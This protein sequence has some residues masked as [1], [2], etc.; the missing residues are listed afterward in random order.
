[1]S[2]MK[3][4]EDIEQRNIID[5]LAN[6]VARNGPKFEELTKSKQKD[7]P[8]FAFLFGGEHHEYYKW[9]VALE[10]TQVEA[11]KQLEAQ[12][13]QQDAT[14]AA[15]Q[16]PHAV[17]SEH[18]KRDNGGEKVA[19]TL[20]L[21]TFRELVQKLI[22]ACTKDNIQNGKNWI[23]NNAKS[24][25]QKEIVAK[26]LFRRLLE[27]VL[28]FQQKLHIVYLA[29]DVLHHSRKK[30]LPQLQD[31]L[32]KYILPIIGVVIN[33]ESIAN[34]QKIAKVLKIWENQSFFME[35]VRSK[36]KDPGLLYDEHL[37]VIE[38]EKS[39]MDKEKLATEKAEEEQ[40]RPE[41]LDKEESMIKVEVPD[42]SPSPLSKV[43]PSS[44]Q[45]QQN[46]VYQQ[47]SAF[48]ASS[49]GQVNPGITQG[50]TQLPHPQ[51]QQSGPHVPRGPSP[52]NSHHQGPRGP[53]QV[54][55]QSQYQQYHQFSQQWNAAPHQRPLQQGL[56][57]MPPQQ[58]Q[59]DQY[60]YY[61]QSYQQHPQDSFDQK[62]RFPP[63]FQPQQQSFPPPNSRDQ[64]FEQGPG[65]AG[66]STWS[67]Q[68]YDMPP[69]HSY[70]SAPPPN[71]QTFDYSHQ[72]VPNQGP[73]ADAP[74]SIDYEHGNAPITEQP[75]IEEQRDP[76]IPLA[77]YYDLP[78]GLIV[79]LVK[80]WDCEYKPIDP[81]DIRL[82]I[83]QPPSERLLAAVEAFYAPPSHDRPRDSQGWEKNGLFEFYKAK[84][85]YIKDKERKPEVI[86]RTPSP[87]A[88]RSS[89]PESVN[90]VTAK[91]SSSRSPSPYQR[92]S[93]SRSRSRSRSGSQERKGRSRTRSRSNT[94]SRSRSHTPKRKGSRSRSRSYSRSRSRSPKKGPPV[95]RSP[96]PPEFV[97]FEAKSYD[98]RIEET[99][100]GHKMLAKMG[101]GGQGLGKQESGI[102]DPIKQDTVREKQD[103][104]KGIGIDVNDPFE[105]Y[106]KNKSYTYSRP[107]GDKRR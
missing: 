99:N 106:R 67:Q 33:G 57:Q 19:D 37:S 15:Q 96:T 42:V 73:G 77:P 104:F 100:I 52:V 63:P 79:P 5:K 55:P 38:N 20:D 76:T 56:Q 51:V 23:V 88:S 29:N 97:P 74:I 34:K 95:E 64:G 59:Q 83:P 11:Q 2:T 39:E 7:S 71:I 49:Q 80:L 102:L 40:P 78:A 75:F 84:I 50:L 60:H 86:H 4:P 98:T 93:K 25:S 9:K 61:N 94:R 87:P 91:P 43:P 68:S 54:P 101:W 46:Y 89:S 3:I 24:N 66:G 36:L 81:K 35:E 107:R 12:K 14:I 41:H 65:G 18:S 10:A 13:R 26:F 62:Q 58:G 27:E 32:E 70:Q 47:T 105:S 28:P 90:L 92:K 69:P 30:D 103:Q 82:P 45:E 85:K 53:V 44:S 48:Q 1:M 16:T 8:K 22:L 6:F 72:S 21:I 17:T 31:A